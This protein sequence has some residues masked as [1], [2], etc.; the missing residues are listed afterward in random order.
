MPLD[1]WGP[2]GRG[3]SALLI[4]QSSSTLEGLMVHVGVIDVDYTG[5]I[6][7][8]VSTVTPPVTIQKGT[9]LAQLL[10]FLSLVPRTEQVVVGTTIWFN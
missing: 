5:Q 7:A 2:V 3:L 8:L 1:A 10:P 9:R 4:G 6:C